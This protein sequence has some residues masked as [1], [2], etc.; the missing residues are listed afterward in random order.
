MSVSI[1]RA[2]YWRQP[3]SGAGVDRVRTAIAALLGLA[4]ACSLAAVILANSLSRGYVN[5]LGERGTARSN[6]GG[7]ASDRQT[8]GGG[9]ASAPRPITRH[10]HDGDDSTASISAGW[11]QE[12]RALR[13]RDQRVRRCVV[14][15]HCRRRLCRK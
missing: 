14:T 8:R 10:P 13:S 12:I 5:A 15:R 6:S 7:E 4:V 3:R 2:T 1:E 11:V 9:R